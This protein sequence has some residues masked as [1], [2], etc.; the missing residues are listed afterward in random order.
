MVVVMMMWSWLMNAVASTVRG[1]NLD[2][3]IVEGVNK[4]DESP[5][6]VQLHQRQLEFVGFEKFKN[7]FHLGEHAHKCAQH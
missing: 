2:P 3:G 4:R 6:L 1:M 5:Y 7:S